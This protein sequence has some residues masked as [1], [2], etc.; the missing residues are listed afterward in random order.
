V[1]EN[2]EEE[3]MAA[4]TIGRPSSGEYAPHFAQYIDLVPDGDVLALLKRQVDETAGLVEP[5]ADRDA[6]FRYA[7]GKW[8]IKEVVGHVADTERIMV[9]RALCFARGEPAA[10]PGFDEDEYVRRAKFASRPLPD[11][12]AEL[13]A[14]RAAT[15]PFF[16]ALDAEQLAR[17][18]TANSRPY[19]VRALAYIVTGHER[20]H[21]RI[22]AE[23]YLPALGKR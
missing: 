23:R 12:V 19:S 4:V 13:R 1:V 22:L 6:D 9:Y 17:R 10:L 14:I 16:A 7:E 3:T 15:L 11:L 8:S 2:L 5:L 21:A 20:H 18:G